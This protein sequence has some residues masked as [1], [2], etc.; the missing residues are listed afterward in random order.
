MIRLICHVAM[1]SRQVYKATDC[2]LCNRKGESEPYKGAVQSQWGW[3]V[4]QYI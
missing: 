2:S 1:P 3:R 4:E